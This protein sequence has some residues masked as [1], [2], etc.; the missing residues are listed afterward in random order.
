MKII[1][2]RHGIHD[3]LEFGDFK[4][5]FPTFPP[6]SVERVSGHPGGTIKKYKSNNNP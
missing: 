5:L 3:Y 4:G 2:E 1:R 6:T